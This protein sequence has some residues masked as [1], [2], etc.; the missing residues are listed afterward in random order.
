MRNADGT[1]VKKTPGQLAQNPRVSLGKRV[2]LPTFNGFNGGGGG[3]V[4]MG[5][6]RRG[7]RVISRTE[8]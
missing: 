1:V 4:W 7:W 2:I 8:R 5:A 6:P 3:L